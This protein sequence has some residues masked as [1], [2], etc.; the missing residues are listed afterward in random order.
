MNKEIKNNSDF[1]FFHNIPYFYKNDY[2]FN[3]MGNLDI[4]E[5]RSKTKLLRNY[6]KHLKNTLFLKDD[7]I[8]KIR[9]KDFTIV[10]FAYEE[11]REKANNF[12]KKKLYKKAIN[13]FTFAYSIMKW[14]ELKEIKK[15]IIFYIF[16]I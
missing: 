8:N 12:Y 3:M 15:G 16:Y 9:N 2:Y 11:V 13:Y 4:L 5:F 6:P 14:L 10:F 7:R 1:E